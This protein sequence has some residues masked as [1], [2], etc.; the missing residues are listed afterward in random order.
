MDRA[1][2][3]HVPTSFELRGVLYADVDL[4]A[5]GSEQFAF[6]AAGHYN[7]PDIFSVTIDTRRRIQFTTRKDEINTALGKETP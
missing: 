2:M 6:D 5:I 4:A 3:D 7:R 1:T